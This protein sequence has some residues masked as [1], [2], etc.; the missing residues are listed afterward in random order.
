M[1]HKIVDQDTR[2]DNFIGTR[3]IRAIHTLTSIENQA[4]GPSYTVPRLCIAL[5][6][7]ECDVQLHTFGE[8][9]TICES[10]VLHRRHAF[11]V[12]LPA[13]LGRLA[14]S[15][16]MRQ[17]VFRSGAD[18]F[19]SHGLWSMAGIYSASASRWTGKPL[20]LSP[21]G[22]LGREAL[23]FSAK[24]KWLF[25]ALMQHRALESVTCFHA[26]AGSEYDDIR[27]C[28][29][30]QPV[31]VIPNGIDI[32]VLQK[33]PGVHPD[34]N[35][36]T[37]PF[38]L[39]LGR[40]HPKKGLDRL[41]AAW[42]HIASDFN[43]WRLRIVGPDE[44]GYASLLKEQVGALGLHG[45]ISIEPPVFGS[46]K[47]DL[48]RRAEVFAL[49]TLHENFAMTVAESLA[50][51]TPVISTKG[52]PWTG[53]ETYGCGWWVEQGVAPLAVALRDA[54]SILPERRQIMGERGRAWMERDFSWDGIARQMADVY[55][56]T[57][58]RGDRPACVRI[59]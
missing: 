4:S 24:K 14:F 47:L 6:K 8:V 41:I 18:V 23:R 54:L 42:G 19:H 27:E 39:S 45:K 11:D 26:T 44:I 51:G 30:T 13:F 2:Q 21:R 29:L 52:A 20:V 7:T 9:S 10:G 16:S 50:L 12:T 36:P 15:K 5:V 31:A 32:P 34:M 40:I 57:A 1:M 53:L 58:G 56:W 3:P 49:P 43:D 35:G 22:M 37:D 28:G 59:G 25:N 46:E 38:V 48:M 33:L 55:L 17:S